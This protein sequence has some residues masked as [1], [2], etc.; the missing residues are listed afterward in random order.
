MEF[1]G[2]SRFHR[3]SRYLKN[4]YGTKVYRIGVDAGFSCPNRGKDRTTGGCIYCEARGAKAPYLLECQDLHRQIEKSIAFMKQRYSATKFLLYFQAFS[5]TYAQVDELKRVYDAA[6]CAADFTGLVV[7]TRPD[8][9][10]EE[11]ADLLASY[12]RKDYSVWVELGLQSMHNSTLRTINR[13]HSLE[14][15]IKAYRMLTKRG[16]NV[17]VHLIF[18]LPGEGEKQILETVR[19]V[20][21]LAP[22]GVKI[23]NLHIPYNTPIFK[24]YE[25]GEI[26]PLQ[27]EEHLDLV[28]KALELLPPETVILRVTCDTPDRLLAAPRNFPDK[29][30]FYQMLD[31]ALE[32][33][34]TYQGKYFEKQE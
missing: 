26:Q 2:D 5:S 10:D 33:Q 34:N 31:A 27:P 30:R 22:D 20:S 3:Y 6:L 7:S 19:F 13:G 4:K 12:R 18:G 1:P 17:A 15:F 21:S 32:A 11:K 24:M 28:I 25:R 14:D 16:I 29:N 23:H 8:C 9:V